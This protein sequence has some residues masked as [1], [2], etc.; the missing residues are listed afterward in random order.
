MFEKATDVHLIL[1]Q[2]FITCFNYRIQL[3]Y[4][5]LVS[6]RLH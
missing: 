3:L 2:I 4:N 5:N 6:I 1:F